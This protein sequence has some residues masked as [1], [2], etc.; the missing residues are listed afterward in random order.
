MNRNANLGLYS[1]KHSFNVK[2]VSALSVMD[3]LHSD[4]IDQRITRELEKLKQQS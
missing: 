4:D 1:T 3:H 2:A